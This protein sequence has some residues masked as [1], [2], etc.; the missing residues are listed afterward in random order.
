[1]VFYRRLDDKLSKAL[2]CLFSYTRQSTIV[3]IY[4]VDQKI[5]KIEAVF[6]KRKTNNE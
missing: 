4:E 3:T 2:E 5:I 6:T 1:M